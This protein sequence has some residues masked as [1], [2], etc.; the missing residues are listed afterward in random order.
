MNLVLKIMTIFAVRELLNSIARSVH[1]FRNY[2]IRRS[3]FHS[4]SNAIGG[5]RKIGRA[6][7]LFIILILNFLLM[8]EP[9]KD[10][11]KGENST[12]TAT[13]SAGDMDTLREYHINTSLDSY[14]HYFARGKEELIHNFL[15]EMN[16]KNRAYC[17]I[18][19]N[20]LFEQ[21]SNYCRKGESS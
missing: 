1:N 16:A 5:S 4:S 15:S 11:S 7:P 19:E 10:D 3:L 18:L 12:Y 14:L 8:R 20:N 17:F 21:F 13:P 9:V 2:N 6:M